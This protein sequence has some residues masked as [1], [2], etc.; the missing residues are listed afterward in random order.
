MGQAPRPPEVRGAVAE[1]DGW[2][3]LSYKAHMRLTDK[4]FSSQL[5]QKVH[6]K[7]LLERKPPAKRVGGTCTFDDKFPRPDMPAKGQI[8]KAAP[9]NSRRAFTYHLPLITYHFSPKV[10]VKYI[11]KLLE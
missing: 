5:T 8:K 11:Y 9:M 7:A 10:M 4:I 6:D 1:G 3:H 2:V